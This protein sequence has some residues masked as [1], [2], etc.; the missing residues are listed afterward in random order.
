MP[1]L[2]FGITVSGL[3]VEQDV[4][5]ESIAWGKANSLFYPIGPGYS[6]AWLVVNG[7]T[8][9][10]LVALSA[11]NNSH[12]I[13]WTRLL[14]PAIGNPQTSTTSFPGWKFIGAERVMQGGPNQDSAL[15]LACFRDARYHAAINSDSG[16]I[17]ANIR[18]YAQNNSY[19]TGTSG[20]T[21]SSL[22]EDLWTNVGVLGAFPGLPGGLSVDSVPETTFFTGHNGYASLNAV[23]EQLDCAICPI[24]TTGLFSIVQLG[25][26]QTLPN[27]L[28][29][30]QQNFEPVKTN[31]D[32][33]ATLKI[34]FNKVL[35]NY[36]QEKDTELVDN[37]AYNGWGN[38][39]SNA[40][41]I[42]GAIGTKSLW[43]DMPI[44]I[45]EDGTDLNTSDRSTR[46]TNRTSRYV[47]RYTSPV[48]HRIYPDILTSV[49]PG[50]MI[51]AI[52]FRCWNDGEENDYGGT[53]TEWLAKPDYVKNQGEFNRGSS[54][55]NTLPAQSNYLPPDLGQH[56][57]PNYPRLPQVVKVHHTSGS[58]SPGD[59][60]SPNA[61]G[62][63]PGYVYRMVDGVYTE[64]EQCWVLLID[65]Y[66]TNLGQVDAIQDE[67]YVARLMGIR[68]CDG[69]TR[70]QYHVRQGGVAPES[71]IHFELIENL[72]LDEIEGMS[73]TSYPAH[74]RAWKLSYNNI[75][76]T[77]GQASEV[78]VY[79]W[80]KANDPANSKGMW[81]AIVPAVTPVSGQSVVRGLAVTRPEAYVDE[82][83]ASAKYIL[84]FNGGVGSSCSVTF[85]VNGTPT[86]TANFDG[87]THTVLDVNDFL[88]DVVDFI[89]TTA[90]GA[91]GDINVTVLSTYA[92]NMQIEITFQGAL[93]YT[94]FAI[95]LDSASGF[96]VAIKE[97]VEGTSDPVELAAYDIIWMERIAQWIEFTAT[98]YMGETTNNSLSASLL[99]GHWDGQGIK[100]VMPD[101]DS[102]NVVVWQRETL[103]LSRWYDVVSGCKGYATYDNHARKYYI[104]ESERLPMWATATANGDQCPDGSINIS[105]FTEIGGGGYSG[106]D[107]N[108]PTSINNPLGIPVLNSDAIILL[109]EGGLALDSLTWTAVVA[110]LHAYDVVVDVNDTGTELEYVTQVIY[111]NYCDTAQTQHTITEIDD[112]P[113]PMAAMPGFIMPQPQLTMW[114]RIKSFFG[115]KS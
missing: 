5:R 60:V 87:T 114:Q 77:W 46:I 23:L 30:P 35:K 57:Y 79:D 115:F 12:T 78:M 74:A 102:Q 67:Y 61:D 69:D 88:D 107:P 15:F 80:Y 108:P 98:E 81:N 41:G 89:A 22:V 58:P 24:P 4:P 47:T 48:Y 40:T 16:T 66:E 94:D 82:N 45:G 103:G 95:T 71:I 52:M 54:N 25:A 10:Q 17:R 27:N 109:R 49:L 50:G 34:Y 68:T 7:A 75:S 9:D 37:W 99:E 28:P 55:S 3:R 105:G 36:G 29:I 84:G 62:Y 51:K 92:N 14:A 53:V 106:S 93:A 39:S 90:G 19:L 8:K 111:V 91:S 11:E 100:P 1:R 112:C 33:A 83:G 21:W 72:Y 59:S 97:V 76:H 2:S 63:H 85:E 43:D 86:S 13:T 32:C 18:S 110:E 31:I 44:L 65:Q 42:T 101:G 20:E 104:Q 6:E 64:L 56:S 113:S 26:T 70:P 38:A 73:P 96:T